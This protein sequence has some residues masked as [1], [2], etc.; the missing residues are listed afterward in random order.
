MYNTAISER[1]HAMRDLCGLT[2]AEMAVATG[3]SEEEYI[4]CE[5]G[6][7][8]FTFTFLSRCADRFQIDMVELITGE[9]PRLTDYIVVQ[10]GMGLPINRREGHEYYHLAAYFKNKIAEPYYVRAPYI[11]SEQ[12]SEIPT[13]TYEGQEMIYVISGSLRFAYDGHEENL[14]AGDSVYYDASKPHGEI[15]TSKDGCEFL[16]ISMKGGRA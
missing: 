10:D 6:Q 16:I 13:S 15:A 12:D 9:N 3:V 11:E 8:D 2:T 1:I 4:R 5:T 14:I 7:Q